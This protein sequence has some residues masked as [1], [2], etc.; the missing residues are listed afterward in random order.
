MR[1]PRRVR[2][3]LLLTIALAG[4]G[5]SD[6]VLA[7]DLRTD[8]GPGLEFDAVEVSVDGGSVQR[9]PVSVED[10]FFDPGRVADFMVQTGDR[11]V[12]LRLL[13]GEDTVFSR[14]LLVTLGED[15]VVTIVVAR[16]CLGVSCGEAEAC[17][18]GRCAQVECS[19]ENPDACPDPECA[20]DADCTA[21]GC[22]AGRCVAGACFIEDNGACGAFGVC[23]VDDC[24]LPDPL[25]AD[26]V[27]WLPLDDPN[28]AM[29]KDFTGTIPNGSCTGPE[30]PSVVN[31]LID[32]AFSLDGV[33]DLVLVPSDPALDFQ[34]AGT[35]MTLN[36][37]VR[38]DTVLVADRPLGDSQ[39]VAVAKPTPGGCV[40]YQ[41]SLLDVGDPELAVRFVIYDTSDTALSAVASPPLTAEQWIMLTGTWDRSVARLYV[42]GEELASVDV[43]SMAFADDDL[44]LGADDEFGTPQDFFAGELDDVRLYGRALDAAEVQRLY[45][46]S[47]PTR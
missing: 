3:L 29:T 34:S 23:G 16:D 19:P 38:P 28:P 13:S 10:T 7:V 43:P 2:A 17:Y 26:L 22:G 41:L 42:N 4:C 46:R 9:R 6:A 25:E 27:M 33:D 32:G 11:L 15:R 21:P 12:T 20:V 18:G 45:E 14:D 5:S 1:Y 37:W 44:R 36:V 8:L 30:C 31:G 39:M 47:A 35:G 24:V 40:S